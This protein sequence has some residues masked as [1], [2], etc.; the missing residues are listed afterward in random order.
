M[1]I[2]L[3]NTWLGKSK[4]KKVRILLDSGSSGSIILEK[5]VHNL[6]M[7]NDNTTN[8]IMKG[9]NFQTSKKC[10]TTFI[11]KEFY[12]NKS[13]EWNLHV[14]SSPGPHQ[15]DMILGRDVLSELGIML[16]FKDQTMTWDDS[17]I[18]MKDPSHF[19]TYWTQ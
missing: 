10:K 6:R 13:I 18:N 2:A 11:L 15:Y 16:D 14:D 4:F 12:G 19:Q 7:K 5:F 3:I 8:W 17:T 1:T 9:G